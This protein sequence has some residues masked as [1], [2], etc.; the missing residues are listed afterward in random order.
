MVIPSRGCHRGVSGASG[1]S[2]E[3]KRQKADYAW[4]DWVPNLFYATPP[5]PSER[6]DQRP[7]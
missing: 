6:G 5:S 1:C 2:E 3:C 4:A 7:Y